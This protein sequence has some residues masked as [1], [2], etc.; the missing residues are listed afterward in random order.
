MYKFLYLDVMCVLCKT[1]GC[2]AICYCT[3]CFRPESHI[4]HTITKE[5][6]IQGYAFCDCGRLERI[7]K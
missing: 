3:D 6:R 1:E 5:T 4:G 2:A 7:K